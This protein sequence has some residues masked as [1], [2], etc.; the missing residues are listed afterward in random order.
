MRLFI[1]QESGTSRAREASFDFKVRHITNILLLSG[2]RT[3]R[4][5]RLGHTA[6]TAL[7]FRF[8]E[9]S[10][11]MLESASEAQIGV[12]WMADFAIHINIVLRLHLFVFKVGT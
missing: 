11:D 6:T 4:G 12:G 8:L 7:S 1:G 9:G 3:R 5:T 2:V 10:Q